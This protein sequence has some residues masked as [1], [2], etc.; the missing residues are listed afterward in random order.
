M[1][2]EFSH[3]TY[4]I[5]LLLAFLSVM[6]ALIGV[7]LALYIGRNDRYVSVGIGFSAGMMLIISLFELV[8]TAIKEAG[9]IT[10]LVATTSGMLIAAVLHWSIPHTHLVEESGVFRQT[11]LKA[12]YLVAFG[13]ILHDVPEGF[14]MANS[15]L[16]APSLGVLIALAIALH[17]IP[18]EFAMAVPIVAIKRQ[19]LLYKA[20]FLSALAEPLGAL[21]GLIA[22]HFHPA[23]NPVFM[24]FAAGVMIFVSVDELIPM[25]RMYG[26]VHHFVL[27]FVMSLLV[28]VLL[29]MLLLN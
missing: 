16:A 19:R 4:L 12:A 24:A 13:L 11:F 14:A 23:L 21:L 7:A 29:G 25:A 17:N 20:A 18:E 27:G 8:P 22:M 26:R 10:V 3:S 5:I 9:V 28:Y 15:Y 6:S 1:S 2:L